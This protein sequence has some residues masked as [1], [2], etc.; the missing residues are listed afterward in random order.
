MH[1][2]PEQQTA[3][4]TALAQGV[5]PE[6][7]AF[8]NDDAAVLERRF[9]A[10]RRNFWA[11]HRNPLAETYRTVE[12]LLGSVSFRELANAYILARPSG[13]A[14]L[15]RYGAGFG[16]FLA[17]QSV[18][19]RHSYLPEVA[20]L[21]WALLAAYGAADAPTCDL[22]AFAAIPADRVGGAR[23]SLHP[24][25]ALIPS[26]YPIA[27]IWHAHRIEDAAARDAALAAIDLTPRP[28]WTL[29]A[30]DSDDVVA[31]TELSAGAGA[32]C[33]V[34]LAGAPLE[35]ALARAVA[36]EPGLA[37]DR[38]LA[39]WVGK[40]W[41]CGLSVESSAEDPRS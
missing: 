35:D 4:G 10:Y 24:S 33:A 6:L 16:D 28:G 18:G 13:D 39:A 19:E 17:T 25:L 11:N 7:A 30:R 15:N 8:F 22:A 34:C 9:A 31:P 3:F 29:A 5:S 12:M 14:D 37:L 21:E 20:R 23:L 1:S 27:A 36:A 32:F 38:L 40:G 2:L 26:D 41:I